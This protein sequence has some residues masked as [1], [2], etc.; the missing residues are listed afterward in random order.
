MMQLS[1]R[2]HGHML[3]VWQCLTNRL[4]ALAAS[5]DLSEGFQYSQTAAAAFCQAAPA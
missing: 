3:L 2:M 5:R 1:A 4:D